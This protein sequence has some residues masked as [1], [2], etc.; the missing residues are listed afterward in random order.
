MQKG[1]LVASQWKGNDQIR[2]YIRGKG[3]SDTQ[4]LIARLKEA[5]D[6][7]LDLFFNS[8]IQYHL[9]VHEEPSKYTSLNKE[10]GIPGT[11]DENGRKV[12][13]NIYYGNIMKMCY[14]HLNR[15]NKKE[16]TDE[17]MVNIFS[18]VIERNKKESNVYERFDDSYIMSSYIGTL[19]EHSRERIDHRKAELRL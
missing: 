12:S 16:S 14:D 10:L 19:S 8:Y 5:K 7:L 4:N 11:K 2:T 1:R 15:L 9:R 6:Y 18:E 3:I 17:S 13:L